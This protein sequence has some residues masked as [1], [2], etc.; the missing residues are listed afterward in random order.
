MAPRFIRTTQKKRSSVSRENGVSPG[1]IMVK[2]ISSL[3]ISTAFAVPPGVMR[4]FVNVSD[5][6]A[7]LLSIIGGKEP[8]HVIWSKSIQTKMA[9]AHG[10]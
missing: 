3:T 7:L 4:T 10:A 6:E 8:G 1:V 5:N 9:K 2:S